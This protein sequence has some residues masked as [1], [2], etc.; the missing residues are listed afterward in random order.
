MSITFV[1]EP[2]VFYERTFLRINSNFDYV[3]FVHNYILRKM[4]LFNK[5]SIFFRERFQKKKKK[6]IKL[7]YLLFNN[8]ENF[9][10]NYIKIFII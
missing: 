7:I 9:I 2:C 8:N 10:I 6:E 4:N 5:K 3:I 1:F